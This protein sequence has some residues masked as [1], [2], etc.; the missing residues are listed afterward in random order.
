MGTVGSPAGCSS[1]RSCCSRACPKPDSWPF[2][3]SSSVIHIAYIYALVERVRPWRLLL[4]YPLAVAVVRSSP[5]SSAPCSSRTGCRGGAWLALLVVAVGPGVVGAAG[6]AAAE[7]AFALLTASMIGWYTV[8]D[9]AGSR[10]T[11][12]GFAYAVVLVFVSGVAMSVVTLRGRGGDLVASLPEQWWRYVLSGA[13]LTAA[14]GLVLI[15]VRHAP[16]GYVARCRESSVVIGALLGWLLLKEPL[17]RRRLRSSIVGRG[18]ARRPRDLPLTRAVRR[19]SGSRRR[20]G[21]RR[22]RPRPR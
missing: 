2:L 10:H 6:R 5:R 9:T 8:V 12:N 4:A 13:C 19:A 18:R 21:A 11:D 7:I 15:A 17:G 1:S 20:R 3:L 22:G 14:Y 16:V